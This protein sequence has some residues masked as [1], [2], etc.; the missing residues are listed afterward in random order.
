MECSSGIPSDGDLAG[1]TERLHAKPVTAAQVEQAAVKPKPVQG[2]TLNAGST[3]PQAAAKDAAL[4]QAAGLSVAAVGKWVL[5]AWIA[6]RVPQAAS[7]SIRLMIGV[8][9]WLGYRCGRT[10]SHLLRGLA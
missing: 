9:V 5:V 6:V 3:A 7:L 2:A 8:A 4:H 1:Y 10:G